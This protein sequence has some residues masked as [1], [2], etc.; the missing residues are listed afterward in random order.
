MIDLPYEHTGFHIVR[1]VG[2]DQVYEPGEEPPTTYAIYARFS[3][4]EYRMET[5]PTLEQ[6]IE[7]L[8]NLSKKAERLKGDRQWTF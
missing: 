1:S 4:T 6:A 3:G 8:E 2:M 5:F 7:A